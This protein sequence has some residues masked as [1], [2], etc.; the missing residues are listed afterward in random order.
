METLHFMGSLCLISSWVTL[1]NSGD[2]QVLNEII[3]CIF[4]NVFTAS[5][6]HKVKKTFGVGVDGNAAEHKAQFTSLVSEMKAKLR[7]DGKLLSVAVLP[8]VNA[9]SEW[10]LISSVN[11]P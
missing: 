1:D 6:W 4:L 10:K 9:S 11:R 5:I 2:V 3:W 7:P 8:H